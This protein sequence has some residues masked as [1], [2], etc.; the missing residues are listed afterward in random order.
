MAIAKINVLLNIKVCFCLFSYECW[1]CITQNCICMF[2][3]YETEQVYFFFVSFAGL[4]DLTSFKFNVQDP[5][6]L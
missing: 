2:A 4:S 1:W 6:S 3:V 5:R